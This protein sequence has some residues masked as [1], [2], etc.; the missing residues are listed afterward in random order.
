MQKL[1]RPST[2]SRGSGDG[3][4]GISLG[5]LFNCLLFERGEIADGE[6]EGGWHNSSSSVPSAGVSLIPHFY[7]SNVLT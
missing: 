5:E 2:R 1:G 7:S 4:S 3:I 6:I